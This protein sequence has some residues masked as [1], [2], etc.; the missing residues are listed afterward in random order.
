MARLILYVFFGCLITN[1]SVKAQIFEGDY[2]PFSLGYVY[3]TVKDDALSPVSYSGNLGSISS[4]YYYQNKKWIN[5]VDLGGFGGFMFPNV[6]R[7]ENPNQVTA[8]SARLQYNL[9]Y[10]VFEHNDWHFFAGLLSHNLWDF[11]SVSRYSNSSFNYNGFF[12]GGV[13]ITIQKPFNLFGESFGFQYGLGIP[14]ATYAWRPGYIKP[15]LSNDFGTEEFYYWDDYFAFDS[16]SDLLWKINE[17]NFI[18]LTYQWEYSQLNPVNK[19][20]AAN[21]FLSISTIFK[22]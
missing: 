4:G 14:V 19:I 3:N 13:K 15:F 16:R 2:M 10:K 22:F 17:S 11:R 21:H 5:A 1:V 20:Q 18:G 9:S 8:L 12:S 6:N 7:E